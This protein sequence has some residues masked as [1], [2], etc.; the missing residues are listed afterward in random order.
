MLMDAIASL[1]PCAREIL[2][3][4]AK[5]L[6]PLHSAVSTPLL[7]VDHAYLIHYS[8]AKERRAFQLQQLPLLGLNISVVMAYDRQEIGREVLAC[9]GLV[10]VGVPMLGTNLSIASEPAYLSQS[11]KL[12]VALY[13]M[14]IH[15]W[16]VAMILEDD[17]VV[18]WEYVGFFGAAVL[19]AT[20]GRDPAGWLPRAKVHKWL[21][22]P[23]VSAEYGFSVLFGGSYDPG[24]ND[25][26]CCSDGP[27]ANVT[28]PKPRDL[29]GF[30]M[31]PISGAAITAASVQHVLRSL[32]FSNA[33]DIVLADSRVASGNQSGQWLIKPCAFVPSAVLQK[34][35]IVTHQHQVHERGKWLE[36]AKSEARRTGRL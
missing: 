29:R 34:G 24:G 9:T 14:A 32:P 27:L 2:H 18:R 5:R 33:Y 21:D 26:V 36:Y 13:H 11:L 4:G 22:R 6:E 30:G 8:R 35:K 19:N 12:H 31:M 10:D 17:V 3:A 1:S 16:R 20:A 23:P 15:G 25:M 28:R 7:P